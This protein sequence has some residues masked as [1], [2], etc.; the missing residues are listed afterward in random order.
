MHRSSHR[1]HRVVAG[2]VALSA[3]LPSLA[4]GIADYERQTARIV[5]AFDFDERGGGNLE[6]VP[7]YWEA[8]RPPTF[9]HF[10]YARFDTGEGHD[11]PPSFRL[12]SEGRNVAYTYRGEETRVRINSGYRVGAFIKPH[13]MRHARA[14]L[15]AHFVDQYGAM[16]PGTLVRSRYVGGDNDPEDWVEVELFLAT[17]PP[18]AYT[19]GL[20]TWVMQSA[21]WDTAPLSK[22]HIPHNDVFA[23]ALFDDITIFTLPRV[24]LSTRH[25]GNVLGAGT[26]PALIVTLADND[27]TKLSGK[28][29]IRASDGYLVET[30]PIKVQLTANAAPHHVSVAHLEPGLYLARIDVTAAGLDIMSRELTFARASPRYRTSDTPARPFGVVIDVQQR[31]DVDTELAMLR[32][33]L[34]GSVKLPVWTGLPEAPTTIQDERTTDR[35]LQELARESFALTA[36][37]AGPPAAIVRAGGKYARPLIDLLGDEPSA[38][39]EH[40]AAIAAPYASVFRSWQIGP[41]DHRTSYTADELETPSRQFREAMRQFI[42]VP[43]LAATVGPLRDTRSTKLPV[44]YVTLQIDPTIAAERIPELVKEQLELGY[45]RVDTFVPPLPQNR[46]RRQ[47]ELA[48]W[49][50]RVITA[51]H[52]GAQTVFTPQAWTVRETTQG[53]TTEPTERYLAFRTIADLL[54]DAVPAHQLPT[55]A[56]V[57]A[58]SFRSGDQVTV[59]AWDDNAPPEGREHTMQLGS[60]TTQ[61]DL[62][63]RTEP[64]RRAEDGRQ[65]VRLRATPV[66][67]PGVE[68]WLN[69]LRT[70]VRLTPTTFESGRDSFRVK[71]E[72]PFR[73]KRSIAGNVVMMMPPSWVSVPRGFSFSLMPQ[74]MEEQE[75]EIQ[76]PHSEVAGPKEIVV[77]IT[78]PDFGYYLEVPLPVDVGVSDVTVSGMAVLEG[79]VLKLRHV[80]TNRSDE[81]LSFRAS[82]SVPGRERQYRPFTNLAP[83]DSQIVEYRFAEAADLVGRD[84]R[85]VLRELSDGPR[86]HNLQMTIP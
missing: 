35:F 53:W 15:S 54:G 13:R 79:D 12:T 19:I 72:I 84:I 56:G 71:I 9:P 44:N 41:D 6:D 50:R 42:T 61:I 66:F 24:E 25:P 81:T 75:L 46:F 33:A 37:F 59:V 82:A 67:I 57:T 65:V 34:L 36:V 80:V 31:S 52:A 74:R 18:Q 4:Q 39:N 64:L 83:G 27:D 30:H 48:S 26:D 78:L 85:L 69:E 45:E 10:T 58:L 70:A 14:C 60:A 28:L 38:W 21:T 16:I 5:H 1:I 62:L 11:A 47:P 55:R 63:G 40:L 68:P 86:I 51:R 7:K 3:P 22:R 8:L 76:I 23:S 2:I 49:A 43:L 32:D 77:A 73:G 29:S 20:T 17:A